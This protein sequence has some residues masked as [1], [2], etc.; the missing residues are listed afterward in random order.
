MTTQPPTEPSI[1]AVDTTMSLCSLGDDILYLIFEQLNIT[2]ESHDV[3]DTSPTNSQMLLKK[4]PKLYYQQRKT[5]P[6]LRLVCKT[7]NQAVLPVRFR[8]FKLK[9]TDVESEVARKVIGDILQWTRCVILYQAATT[10]WSLIER[11][12]SDEKGVVLPRMETIKYSIPL[13]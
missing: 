6:I 7:F 3:Q 13:S 10:D 4:F 1:L 2:D 8:A 11:I 5:L 12:Y 9:L